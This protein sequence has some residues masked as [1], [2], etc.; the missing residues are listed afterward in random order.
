M[1]RDVSAVLEVCRL[2][3]CVIAFALCVYAVEYLFPP[4]PPAD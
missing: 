3:N 4:H 1:S 2:L